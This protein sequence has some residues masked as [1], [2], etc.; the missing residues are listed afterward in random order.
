VTTWETIWL[1]L[2]THGFRLLLVGGIGYASAYLLRRLARRLGAW[3][4]EQQEE[5]DPVRAEEREQRANTLQ[6]VL[7]GAILFLVLAIAGAMALWELGVQIGPL[8][9]GAGVIGI[10]VSLGAQTLVK[11]F[12]AGLFV[13]IEDQFAIGDTIEVASVSG[14]VEQITLRA[15]TLRAFDGTVHI[16]PNGEM[17]IVSNKT[18]DWA[19]VL[20]RV[21]VAYDT[22]LDHAI[23]VLQQ[24][25]WGLSKEPEWDACVLTDPMVPGVDDLG[26]SD[27]V[28]LTVIKTAPGDQ[29]AVAREM[30]KRI[31]A[32]FAREGIEMP[33]PTQVRI[34]R[35]FEDK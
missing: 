18:K 12:L 20:L 3:L 8:L 13:L 6:R 17:R 1:W 19:Q 29:W 10:A 16:I 23:E 11:D 34:S 28:L 2:R 14:V 31:V 7:D 24:V 27:I 21:G 22:D 35:T 30:R 4:I 32:A 5:A 33:Y 9:A 15:T 25:A 26:E